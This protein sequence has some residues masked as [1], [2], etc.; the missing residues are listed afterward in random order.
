V[1]YFANK[2]KT[3]IIKDVTGDRD[4]EY[5]TFLPLILSTFTFGLDADCGMQLLEVN[6]SQR[7]RQNIRHLLLCCYKTKLDPAL[8]NT[9]TDEMIPHINMLTPIV[10]DEVLAQ[11]YSR[12]I[13][14]QQL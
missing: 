4:L 1:A 7:L 6:T 11:R 3:T 2:L 5:S 13:I 14:H 12:L 10:E 9:L 8:I